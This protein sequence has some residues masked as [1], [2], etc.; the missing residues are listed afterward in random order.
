[1]HWWRQVFMKKWHY[2]NALMTGELYMIMFNG[3]STFIVFWTVGRNPM[4]HGEYKF[5]SVKLG[6]QKVFFLHILCNSLHFF[7]PFRR[8]WNYSLFCTLFYA[9][10]VS[11]PA[12][13]NATLL[14]INE[15]DELMNPYPQF[16][17]PYP[18]MK[19]HIQATYFY[20]YYTQQ[21]GGIGV[22]LYTGKQ[23]SCP[24]QCC[25]NWI[26]TSARILEIQI[27]PWVLVHEWRP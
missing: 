12:W 10:F 18:H 11:K 27:R 16:M 15:I 17:N 24:H 3:H 2:K 23:T 22:C 26:V 13:Y 1:M 14:S 19:R 21:N 6:A 7:K 9:S 20:A 5:W 25:A 8:L 4:H